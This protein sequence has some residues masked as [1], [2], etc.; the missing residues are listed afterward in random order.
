MKKQRIENKLDSKKHICFVS[1]GHISSNPRLIK[2]ATLLA[3][4]GYQVSVIGIQTLEKLVPFDNELIKKNP[5]W[6]TF[7]YP[8]YKKG[9]LYL[10]GTAFHHFAKQL[11]KL[12]NQ[13]VLGKLSSSTSLWLPLYYSLKSVK[14]DLYI[15]HNINM[16]PL[17]AKIAKKNNAKIGFD[18]EDAYSVT[19]KE[20]DKNIVELEKKYLPKTDYITCASPL[21]VD[22]YDKLYQKLPNILPILNVFDDIEEQENK[23]YKDRNNTNHLSLYWFSQTTGKGRGIEQII[24]ALSLLDR[25]DI[26]LHLRGEASQE[27]K[28]YFL[29]LATTEN[30]KQNIF[31]HA[32]VS[33]QELPFR[34]AEHDVGLALELKEPVNRNLCLTNKI[35]QY[36]NTGL[37]ILA[38]DTEAQYQVMTKNIETGFLIDIQNIQQIAQK[39][40]V[41]A[42]SKKNNSDVLGKMKIAS[43]NLSKTKYNWDIEGQKF[44]EVIE[45]ILS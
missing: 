32:L 30:T 24:E 36:M 33:N 12:A 8:F 26:E 3:N 11:S 39:I 20:M 29:D 37:A 35:F 38:S 44:L 5:T 25:K 6:N 16:L 42:D 41:L 17:V 43:K 14:A 2:E 18:I 4:K 40:E 13:F 1:V 28:K 19:S 7:I 27:T 45:K 34:T 22:F 23:E 15:A 31:F 21:Y 10:F 9:M